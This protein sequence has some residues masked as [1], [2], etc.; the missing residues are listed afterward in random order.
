MDRIIDGMLRVEEKRGG[1]ELCKP[2]MLESI[3]RI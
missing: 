2:C 1:T 3:D